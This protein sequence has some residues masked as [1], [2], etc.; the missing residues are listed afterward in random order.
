MSKLFKVT[1]KQGNKTSTTTL[2][3]PSWEAAKIFCEAV[4]T[5]KVTEIQEIVYTND[6]TPPVDTFDYFKSFK[7]IIKA[8]GN[9]WQIQ[10]HNIRKTLNEREIAILIKEN[11][12]VSGATVD[13]IFVPAF[14]Y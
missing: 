6:T 9:A 11:L 1:M 8:N 4:T 10:L 14:K 13:D 7:C 3:A 2:E 5:Q 12:R